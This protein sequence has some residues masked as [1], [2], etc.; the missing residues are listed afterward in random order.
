VIV[1]VRDMTYLLGSTLVRTNISSG[2]KIKTKV[3]HMIAILKIRPS[4]KHY[5][6][7]K[8]NW[9]QYRTHV[10]PIRLQEALTHFFFTGIIPLLS[11]YAWESRS[12][13]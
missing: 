12:N 8:A 6:F 5:D 7:V 10:L 2:I 13:S 3:D 4:L 9:T 1:S 11:S